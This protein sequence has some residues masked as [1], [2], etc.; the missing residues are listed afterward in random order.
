MGIGEYREYVVNKN[1]EVYIKP[2][3][4]E[5]ISSKLYMLVVNDCIQ[6]RTEEQHKALLETLKYK[7]VTTDS[8]DDKKRYDWVRFYSKSLNLIG[9]EKINLGRE[10]VF[11]RQISGT[12]IVEKC[13]DCVKI[14]HPKIFEY[15]KNTS[16]VR[17][18]RR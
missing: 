18:T 7:V 9:N 15:M 10:L 13:C 11:S 1:R 14:W 4:D 5:A 16:K 8:V 17:K 6:I 12:V 3:F 2:F